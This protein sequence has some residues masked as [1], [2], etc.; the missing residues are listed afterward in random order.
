MERPIG[1]WAVHRARVAIVLAV[2][3][4]VVV[5]S[6]CTGGGKSAPTSTRSADVPVTDAATST[7]VIDASGLPQLED[8]LAPDWKPETRSDE[9]MQAIGDGS[10]SPTVQQAIDAFSVSYV[11]MPGATPSSL[12]PGDGVGTHTALRLIE[13]A[14]AQLA[15]EQL[16]VLDS[17][18]AGSTD[19]VLVPAPGTDTT[20]LTTTP[21]TTLTTTTDLT[22][23]TA[24][25]SGFRAPARPRLDP[26]ADRY[27]T[28]LKKAYGDWHT[29]RPTMPQTPLALVMSPTPAGPADM[30]A[31]YPVSWPE[32]NGADTVCR[33][34]VYPQLWKSTQPDDVILTAF[35]HE[36]FHCTQD[37]W[38][39][40]PGFPSWL[41]EGSATFAAF[42]LYKKSFP[43]P[44]R[45]S[46]AT[47]YTKSMRPL[48]ARKYDS[49]PL[50]ETF[51]QNK[52]DVYEAV[53]NAMVAGPGTTTALLTAAKMNDQ[54][55]RVMWSS[56]N[57]RSGTF[58]ER[59]WQTD[60]PA[61]PQFGPHDNLT[62]MGTRGVGAFNVK[63]SKKYSQQQVSITMEPK[64]GLVLALAH[65]GP[66]LTHS[67]SDTVAIGEGTTRKFCFDK[68]GC[69]CPNGFTA[70]A[71]QMKGHDMV[72][73]FPAQPERGT[74]LVLA[75]EWD[76]S[77]YC[78][79]PEQ[80]TGQH[81]G[82]PHLRSFD[83]QAFDL[84]APGEFVAARDSR[85]GF[86]VQVRNQVM[87]G[88]G[89]GTSVVALGTGAHRIVFGGDLSAP[90]DNT[91]AVDGKSADPAAGVDVG[92]VTVKPSEHNNWSAT[93]PDGSVVGLHWNHGWF[94]T[95]ALDPARAAHV[96]GLLG[97]PNGNVLDDLL[98]PDGTHVD[99]SD[100]TAIDERYAPLWYVD[101]SRS[102]FDY[103]PGETTL[104]FRARPPDPP[105][106]DAKFVTSCASGM[107]ADATT[108]EVDACAYDVA[109]TG[110][111]SFVAAYSQVVTTRVAADP[112]SAAIHQ[113][114]APPSGGPAPSGSS[115]TLSGTLASAVG[116]AGVVD[117]LTATI[118]VKEGSIILGQAQLCAPGRDVTMRATLRG[119]DKYNDAHLC[120]ASGFNVKLHD[121][122]EVVAGE[123]AL[124]AT[125]G[126]TY[127][128]RVTTSS[129]QPLVTNVR[130]STDPT[131]TIVDAATFVSKGFSGHLAGRGDTVVLL[132]NTGTA[133]VTWTS[134]GMDKAC[135]DAQFGADP[136]GGGALM[137]IGVCGHRTVVNGSPNGDLVV[138]FVIYAHT[139][140]P[141]DLSFVPQPG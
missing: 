51:R 77:K 129:D 39:P 96:T 73:S 53:R 43:P 75:V 19:A 136:L 4:A 28:L 97:T 138:P 62:S 55:F 99:P 141:V 52:G 41:V 137:G 118:E 8:V 115:V 134:T 18:D 82:D 140:D 16:A 117:Q 58:P 59:E 32:P 127:D 1:R 21:T 20:T 78:G 102:L 92:D 37:T 45:Y 139:D 64:V 131:P 36:L 12:P 9:L 107:P 34:R 14:R 85:G 95:V 94:V 26:I 31:L 69:T 48:A 112:V 42:D 33:I 72:F 79:Q 23:T 126:G 103:K 40:G 70:G 124:W 89:T 74:S 5:V 106:V 104:T 10:A 25:V 93:W 87:S 11:P 6:S 15:P 35:A 123:A 30:D 125:K 108:V 109:V 120:D 50:F 57:L 61:T 2:V 65:D 44:D 81:N 101:Q 7:T 114:V 54:Y 113:R 71:I 83:G 29:F 49:W 128:I 38:N 56:N 119:T 100:R 130:V 116:A 63:G 27:L 111:D 135:G 110:D 121:T 68:S 67:A 17:L 60:W 46:P 3:L 98:M 133:F 80:P 122:D 105:T 47:W 84:M 22:T 91:L 13:A 86:E 24:A 132:I 76:A 66:M 88:H 90:A